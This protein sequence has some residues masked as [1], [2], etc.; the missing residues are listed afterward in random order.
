MQQAGTS[1]ARGF[2][3][4]VST[5]LSPLSACTHAQAHSLT[6]YTEVFLQCFAAPSN[7]QNHIPGHLAAAQGLPSALTTLCSA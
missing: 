3:Q 2:S 5:Q 6:G 7:V 4:H 1:S